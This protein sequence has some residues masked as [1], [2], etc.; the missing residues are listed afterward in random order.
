V[1]AGIPLV[2]VAAAGAGYLVGAAGRARLGVALADARRR[3]GTD[4]LTGLPNRAALAAHLAR[5]SGRFAVLLCDLDGFKP[6]N[7]RHGHAAGDAVLVEVAR[8]LAALASTAGG[9]V[10]RL[11]GDEF[12]R[13]VPAQHARQLAATVG[14]EVAR[15]VVVG[16]QALSVGA[17][18]G[19]AYAAP[20]LP[21]TEVL[22]RADVAMYRAKTTRTVAEYADATTTTETGRPVARWRD[23]PR[24]AEPAGVGRPV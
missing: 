5:R 17:S 4:P 11:G 7:D 9:F 2:A 20:G 19:V 8:R 14:G 6:V 13:A 12:V 15:P 1:R 3:A 18:V 10:A 22:H 16:D 21:A 24:L 23:M